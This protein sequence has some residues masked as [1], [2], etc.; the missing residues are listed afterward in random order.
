MEVT[1]D[2]SFCESLDAFH[3]SLQLFALKGA[4]SE[5]FTEEV[6]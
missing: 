1:C 2:I 3:V 6:L 4:F 5:T